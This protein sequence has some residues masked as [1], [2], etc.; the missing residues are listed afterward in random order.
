MH[1]D[2]YD[3]F[4]YHLEP[5]ISGESICFDL[6]HCTT[7]S[8][9]ANVIVMTEY[10]VTIWGQLR[11]ASHILLSGILV[12]VFTISSCH[13]GYACECVAEIIS[14]ANGVYTCHLTSINA[15][16][17]FTVIF[18]NNPKDY[19]IFSLPLSD[20]TP[21]PEVLSLYQTALLQYLPVSF[22]L[23]HFVILMP[24]LPS[25]TCYALPHYT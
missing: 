1:A 4:H 3:M 11:S 14:D 22:H 25:S 16:Y 13:S 20:D 5:M 18:A 21:P 15:S 8:I 10:M 24:I 9:Q 12:K 23:S 19:K 2:T 7:P 6:A 17:C